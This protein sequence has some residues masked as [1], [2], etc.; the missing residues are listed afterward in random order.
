MPTPLNPRLTPWANFFRTSGAAVC[1]V[2]QSAS[3]LKIRNRSRRQHP[4]ISDSHHWTAESRGLCSERMTMIELCAKC[5]LNE[6]TVH[7]TTVMDGEE[8]MVHLCPDCA[9]PTGFDLHNLDLKEIEA[10][11]VIGKKCELCGRDAISGEMCANGRAT[12]WCFDCGLELGRIFSDLI[13]AE[14]PDLLQRSEEENSF[15]SFCSDSGIQ[16]WADSASQKAVKTLKDRRRQG[17]RDKC[18]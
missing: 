6:A 16:A 5:H 17:G 13:V 18:S 10:L 11:S 8:E 3:K 4:K 9:P 2:P 7:F 14:R 15:L 1:R 12:Y